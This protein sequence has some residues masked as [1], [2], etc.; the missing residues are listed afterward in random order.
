M[1][2]LLTHLHGVPYPQTAS[3]IIYSSIKNFLGLLFS[4]SRYRLAI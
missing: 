4:S 2:L 3:E 1:D